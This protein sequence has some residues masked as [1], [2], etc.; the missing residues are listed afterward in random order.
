MHGPELYRVKGRSRARRRIPIGSLADSKPGQRLPSPI[1]VWRDRPRLSE[2]LA[3]GRVLRALEC[4]TPLSAM[5]G[6]RAR[7]GE[8]RFDLLWLSGFADATVMGLPDAEPYP[9]RQRLDRIG[10]I[11]A[12][13]HLP[14][15]ADGD[16][17]GDLETCRQLCVTLR[18]MGV[19]GVVFED[20]RGQKRTSLA[21]EARHELEDP[22]QF[23]VKIDAAKAALENGE[24][25]IFA[26]IEALIAGAGLED[27]ILRA[28]HYL[29]SRADGI[30][31]HS[32]D[33]T[34]QEVLAFMA[35]YEALE[36]ELGLRKPLVLIPTAYS[37]LTAKALHA[38]GAA[39]V[40]HGNHMVRAACKA[41]QDAAET[42][43]RTDCGR[44]A[45]GQIATVTEILDLVGTE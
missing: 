45:D 31:I 43:L 3:Q 16:T 44:D 13:T 14:L 12:R 9:T 15:L 38:R 19:S 40:I 33:K 42:I 25:L 29:S 23:A 41:M 24:F 7:A 18:D 6:E 22:A 1:P 8:A 20:K 11:A 37:H 36:K 26:R 35:R 32:K 4:H 27:A 5:L 34:G 10:D 2:L 17:G 21:E 28:R 30:V 39:I